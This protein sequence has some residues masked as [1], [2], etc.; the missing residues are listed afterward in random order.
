M[1]WLQSG[2]GMGGEWAREWIGDGLRSVWVGW[3]VSLRVY[4]GVSWREGALAILGSNEKH[5][6]SFWGFWGGAQWF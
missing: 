1:G 4:E 3:M 6:Y 2:W 5:A